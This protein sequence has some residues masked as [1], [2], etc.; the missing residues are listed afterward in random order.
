MDRTV[1]SQNNIP[2]ST[3]EECRDYW[4]FCEFVDWLTCILIDDHHVDG[5]RYIADLDE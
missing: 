5:Y 1:F 2:L 4:A 3:G